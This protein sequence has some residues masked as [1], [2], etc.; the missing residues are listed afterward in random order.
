[1]V[2]W[3]RCPRDLCDRERCESLHL[4]QAACVKDDVGTGSG[5]HAHDVGRE[6]LAG[7]R[8]GGE[9]R[10]FDDRQ[11]ETVAALPRHVTRAESDADLDWYFAP[12]AVTIDCLLDRDR[13]CCG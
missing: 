6:D 4:V 13:T 8:G 10:G 11:S 3:Q 1:M 7:F 12:A 2:W 9:S 5:Q